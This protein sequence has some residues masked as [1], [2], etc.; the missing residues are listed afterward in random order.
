[1]KDLGRGYGYRSIKLIS[2]IGEKFRLSVGFWILCLIRLVLDEGI[3]N[4]VGKGY[5]VLEMNDEEDG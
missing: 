2:E 3:G 5:I 4:I 1:M